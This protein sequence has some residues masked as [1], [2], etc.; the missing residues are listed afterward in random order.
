MEYL[1]L[2]PESVQKEFNRLKDS[3]INPSEKLCRKITEEEMQCTIHYLSTFPEST[4]EKIFE[5]CEDSYIL[6]K[7]M[8][9]GF[10]TLNPFT[11]HFLN[12]ISKFY[13]NLTLKVGM[14]SFI[15]SIIEANICDGV[16]TSQTDENKLFDDIIYHE[17]R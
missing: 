14:L 12:F 9:Y 13:P 1:N 5:F 11:K 3:W 17:I 16:G 6:S 4:Y 15:D 10:P 8:K 7:D 2:L